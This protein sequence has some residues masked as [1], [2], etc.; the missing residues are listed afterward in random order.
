MVSLWKLV[1]WK[2]G[3]TETQARS[4]SNVQPSAPHKAVCSHSSALLASPSLSQVLLL[5]RWGLVILQRTEQYCCS[6]IRVHMFSWHLA[7]PRPKPTARCGSGSLH[8]SSAL[9][10]QVFMEPIHGLSCY[11][12][13]CRGHL[14]AP[15]LL[16]ALLTLRRSVTGSQSQQWEIPSNLARPH[17]TS[18]RLA[19]LNQESHLAKEAGGKN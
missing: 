5:H 3:S 8:A 18:W 16:H 10:A 11:S 13:V 1:S 15:H 17:R 19:Q 7:L 2:T 6:I 9:H 14:Q 12:K 4:K